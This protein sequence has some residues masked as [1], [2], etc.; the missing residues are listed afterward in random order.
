MQSF[1][2]K[3]AKSFIT[4]VCMYILNILFVSISIIIYYVF[5]NVCMDILNTSVRVSNII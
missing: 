3:R 2:I 1:V 4:N 5:S